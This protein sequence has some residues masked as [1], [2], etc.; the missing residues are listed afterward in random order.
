MDFRQELFVLVE[1]FCNQRQ[2]LDIAS[3]ANEIAK[4]RYDTNVQTYLIGM[5]ST[6]DLNDS[7]Q[8]KDESMRNYINELYLYWNYWYQIRSVTLFDYQTYGLIDNDVARYIEQ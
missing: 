1:R 5:I 2:Q 3:R 6:L 4:Q 8:R 7:Q